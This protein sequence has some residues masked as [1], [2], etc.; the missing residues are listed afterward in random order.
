MA[1]AGARTT[2]TVRTGALFLV[3]TLL[4]APASAQDTVSEGAQWEVRPSQADFERLGPPDAV[5]ARTSGRVTLDCSLDAAGRL[6][7]C[8]VMAE[9][10]AGAGFGAS[11]LRLASLYRLARTRE[12]NLDGSRLTFVMRFR[13]P[14]LDAPPAAPTTAAASS[15]PP[16]MAAFTAPPGRMMRIAEVPGW[17]VEFLDLDRLTLTDGVA[18]AYRLTI[19]AASREAGDPPAAYEISRVRVDCRSGDQLF[20]GAQAFSRDGRV[21]ASR[22]PAAAMTNVDPDGVEAVVGE[23]ACDPEWVRTDATGFAEAFS[24]ARQVL[25]GAD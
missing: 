18:E 22:P 20:G 2:R 15:P 8:S 9:S 6:R 3:V 13:Y 21:V 5:Q 24:K 4:C 1:K 10:P 12:V 11:A 25:D 17:Q 16:A 23:K 14:P 19:Y 7:D